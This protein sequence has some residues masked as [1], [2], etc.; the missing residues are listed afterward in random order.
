MGR[1]KR[2]SVLGGLAAVCVVGAVLALLIDGGSSTPARGSA[3]TS[4][5][6]KA[7]R[8]LATHIE[9]SRS[10]RRTAVEAYVSGVAATCAGALKHAPPLRARPRYLR[11]GST[12]V[13]DPQAVLFSDAAGGIEQ[14]M[15]RVDAN[16]TREFARETRGLRWTDPALTKLVHALADVEDAQLEQQM[17][18][19]CRDAR[20][21]AA[22]GY[23]SLAARTSHTAERFPAA[24]EVLTRELAKQG[25]VSRVPGR[26][27]LHVLEE[28]LARGQRTAAEETSGLEARVVQE[29]VAMVNNAIARIE[30]VLGTR[31]NAKSATRGAGNVGPA[32]VAVPRR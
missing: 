21:W 31:L 6:V 16:A 19:L 3:P 25:C 9:R 14:A 20:A 8:A 7:R 30:K 1:A 5:Y 18:E 29:D 17:P 24:E 4:T 12:L 27:V 11:E 10:T 22:S 32:C 28:H 15:H 26:G 23:R 13:L 2:A